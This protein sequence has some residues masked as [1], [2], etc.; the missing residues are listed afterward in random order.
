MLE[1]LDNVLHVNDDILFYIEDFN[2]VSFIACQRHILAADLGKVKLDID[3]NFYEDNRDTIMQVRLL[4]W[5]SDFKKHKG[6]KKKKKSRINAISM[7]S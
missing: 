3:N 1:K 5:R 6:L 2:K 7:T 4:A